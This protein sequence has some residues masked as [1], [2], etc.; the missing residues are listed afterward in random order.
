ME[1]HLKTLG[2]LRKKCH[3]P[4]RVTSA[5]KAVVEKQARYRSGKPL[6]HPKAKALADATVGTHRPKKQNQRSFSAGC[7]AVRARILAVA[8]LIVV[9]PARTLAREGF[10]CGMFFE[11]PDRTL[12]V[13][14]QKAREIAA[15]AEAGENSL[16][17]E[18]TAIRRHGIGWNLPSF[19]TKAICQII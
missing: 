7:Q 9:I 10:R 4:P 15:Q 17:N 14:K 16:H 6:R 3:L 1:S 18:I 8:V 12:Q 2:R 5:A 19:H 11:I 13:F